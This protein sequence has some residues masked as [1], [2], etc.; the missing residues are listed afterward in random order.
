[1]PPCP[2]PLLSALPQ[3]AVLAA[4]LLFAAACSDTPAGM[5]DGSPSADGSD[6]TTDVGLDGGRA[7]GDDRDTRD[8]GDDDATT[9]DAGSTEGSDTD[10]PLDTSDGGS[11]TD[12]G[13]AAFDG[14]DPGPDAL[15]DGGGRDSDSRDSDRDGG[16]PDGGRD[17]GG[18]DGGPHDAGDA[19]TG[20]A[21]GGEPDTGTPPPAPTGHLFVAAHQDDD[22]LFMSPDLLYTLRSDDVV[23][24]LFVT[25]GDACLSRR[26]IDRERG[27][28]G[29]YSLM[30]SGEIDPDAFTCVD[31]RPTGRR[32]RLCTWSADDR[33]TLAFLRLPDC[34]GALEPLWADW[35]ATIDSVDETP[36]TWSGEDI[37]ARIGHDVRAV[38]A[39]TLHTLDSSDVYGAD[40]SDHVQSARFAF[41]AHRRLEP[42]PRLRLHRTYNMDREHQNVLGPDLE[43]KFAAVV[44]YCE[45]SGEAAECV[46]RG[47]VPFWEWSRRQYPIVDRSA[48]RG[49][50]RAGDGRCVGA[51]E[52]EAAAL[53]SCTSPD[54]NDWR[55][56]ER[57]LRADGERCLHASGE[58]G[59]EVVIG[60]C[61]EGIDAQRWT[62]MTNG[63]VRG[64]RG[65]CLDAPPDGPLRLAPCVAEDAQPAAAQ[66]WSF[67]VGRTW[68]PPGAAAFSDVS[69]GDTSIRSLA[70]TDATGDGLADACVRG[71]DG[72]L[73][74]RSTGSGFGATSIWTVSF[75]D[76]AG[77][78]PESR[79]GTIV[80]GDLTGEGRADVCGRG[81]LGM[82]CA[83][84]IDWG[85]RGL[86]NWEDTWLADRGDDWASPSHYGSLSLGD[87]DGDG[88]ADVCGRTAGGIVCARNEG[89][90][91]GAPMPWLDDEFTDALGW[92]PAFYG[93]TLTL[94]DVDGDGL[95]DVCGRGGAGPFC[96][97]SH[98]D[99]FSPGRFWGYRDRF[100]NGAGWA[101][102]ES[103]WGS[104]RL[105]D[106]DGDGRAD[107]CG[108]S[109]SGLVCGLSTGS[110]FARPLPV[111]DG[112]FA[113]EAGF[114]AVRHGGGITW[115][116]IDGDGL[117][118]ACGRTTVGL[119]CS[120]PRMPA[121]D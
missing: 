5:Y 77:W 8:T 117:V 62:V 65:A 69:V 106:V 105:P 120:D 63:Q 17:G 18:A 51:E 81:R 36:D 39:G 99:G 67:L 46:D 9:G 119:T 42:A 12:P 92:S 66:T 83:P 94:G 56:T 112:A 50:L 6:G 90:A 96:A 118:E 28:Q 15:A 75:A 87:L 14:D 21:D 29:A 86:A 115:G 59:D 85:F 53:V 1:M 7:D 2:G 102:D 3:R 73:C 64:I 27:I 104:L 88:L 89:G 32:V 23:R 44:A 95:A 74:A 55:L 97:L 49:R 57:T 38:G 60:P 58:P 108:R 24:T 10:R 109:P 80:F 114:A 113:D 98:G 84:S 20:D 48:A 41:E 76:S 13:D 121:P 22:L 16:G 68:A 101:D 19:D 91:F 43:A 30:L 78:A 40:H 34:S 107:Y 111:D 4:I 35:S 93:A 33:V 45:I 54:A 70:L 72:V 26:P 47:G 110:T 103:R 52:G 37:I 100:G 61:I 82:L 25:G 31:E 116:D 79:D 11:D 71:T